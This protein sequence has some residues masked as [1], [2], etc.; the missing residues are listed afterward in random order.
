VL[1]KR[2]AVQAHRRIDLQA[3][4]AIVGPDGGGPAPP[5]DRTPPRL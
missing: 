2:R 3:L 1:R 5:P 4:E